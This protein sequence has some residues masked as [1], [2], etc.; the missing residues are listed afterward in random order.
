MQAVF[1][2]LPKGIVHAIQSLP[3]ASQLTIEEIR[4]RI[5]RPL[6]VIAGGRSYIC[7][8]VVQMEEGIEL[9]NK[10]S[11]YSLYTI[12][13]ELKKDTLLFKVDIASV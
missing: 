3:I 8:H 6:E 4:I 11:Q 5:E 1:D 10:L 9:L 7:P 2:M 13:E 12:E